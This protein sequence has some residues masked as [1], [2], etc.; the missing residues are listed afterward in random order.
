MLDLDAK[1]SQE[2]FRAAQAYL[3]ATLHVSPSLK[4]WGARNGL[5]LFLANGFD[6]RQTELFGRAILLSVPLSDSTKSPTGLSKQLGSL[7]RHFEGIIVLVLEN[8][9]A[10]QRSRLIEE[11]AAFIV[12]GNQLFVPQLAMDLR[13]HFRRKRSF[14]EDQLSPVAQALFLRHLNLGDV[15]GA[16]PSD[17]AE[18]LRYSAMSIG[19]AFEE[20][21]ASGLAHIEAR[22]RSKHI[23][24]TDTPRELFETAAPRL[25]SPVKAEHW[26]RAPSLPQ[27]FYG[28]PLPQYLPIG[29]EGALAER[30][31]MSRPRLVRFAAGPKDW[32]RLQS[33]EFGREINQNEEPDFGV[34]VWWYD[35]D[36]VSGAHEIDALSLYLQF[37]NHPDERL[38]AAA[39][40]LMEEFAW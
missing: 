33:G 26:F 29:G 40:Q 23:R 10:Y 3:R 35:P 13:E 27:G 30:S 5:P 9:S 39:E 8:L 11:S 32:K 28:S 7:Q 6:F 24:F 12:P 15:E 20:L 38:E 14:T 18:T 37:R 34:D 19:R 4:A 21:S 22:G 1:P 36:I 16:R 25:R 17:L 31:A 2:L